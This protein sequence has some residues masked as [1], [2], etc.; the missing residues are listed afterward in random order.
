VTVQF[1]IVMT[2]F[3]PFELLPRALCC[4]LAQSHLEWE[5]VVVVDGPPPGA[6]APERLVGQLG[7]CFG[8][9][10]V[11][12]HH[13]PRAEGCYGNVARNF[14]L[15]R[16]RGDYVCWVNHDNLIAPAYLEAHRENV[17]KSPGCVSVV[18]IDLWQ[19]DRYHG[20]YPRR[21]AAS[22]I[23]LLCFAVP[24]TLARRVDAFGGK[25]A[26]VYAADW[27]VFDACRKLAPVEQNRRLVGTHF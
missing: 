26:G 14:G 6:F 12:V 5:L 3:E 24:T 2:A 7:A 18:D 13:L 23:D 17:E 16:V 9:R 8:T 10:R 25:A 15:G 27:L 4:V 22:N 21:M 11:E 19:G 1:S 20:R